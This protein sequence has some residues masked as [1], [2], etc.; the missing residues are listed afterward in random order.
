M[1]KNNEN[2]IPNKISVVVV[3][4]H[5]MVREMWAQLFA[6]NPNIELAGES[7]VFDEAIE[8]ISLK[9]PD[10][11]LL[12]INI[13]LDSGFDAMPLI[14]KNS[15][16]TRV[17]AVSMH[18]QPSYAK[19]MIRSGAK[20]YVTKNSSRTEM[21]KAIDEVISGKIYICD[22]IKEI[23]SEQL[24]FPEV[25]SDVIQLS[26]REMEIIKYLKEGL[27]SKEIS[28]YMQI[29]HRTVEVHR[30]NMLKKMKVKNTASLINYFNTSYLNFN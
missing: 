11:V 16:G 17:I 26:Q 23:L 27:S 12:D 28:T 22:E 1:M 6:T 29:A 20:G 14:R 24:L 21:F 2:M 9:K 15:P 3:D 10:L 19:K 30:Y 5:K 8:M 4:D 25:K 18:A 7:G 13:G